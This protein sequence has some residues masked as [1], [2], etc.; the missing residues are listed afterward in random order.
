MG[1][2][3]FERLFSPFFLLAIHLHP[4]EDGEFSLFYMLNAAGYIKPWNS[5]SH[6]HFSGDG[7][8]NCSL[9][10]KYDCVGRRARFNREEYIRI[11][12]MEP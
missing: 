6:I 11:F 9:C 2:S 1:K 3:F 8:Q 10:R 5:G 7:Y 4:V 12:G